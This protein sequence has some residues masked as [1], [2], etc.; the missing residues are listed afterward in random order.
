MRGWRARGESLQLL[1]ERRLELAP[2]VLVIAD[3]SGAVAM[4][5]VMGGLGTSITADS[6]EVLLEVAFFAP[7]AMAGR[8]R[9]YGVL[10]DGGQRFERG[11]DPQGQARA[12]ERATGLLLQ[13]CGGKAGP[14]QESVAASHLPARTPG[15]AAP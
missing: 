8:G 12:M 7:D 6:T 3:D 10:T 4:A 9:R 5:G 13:L 11:V 1:D 2:D 15:G 14:V